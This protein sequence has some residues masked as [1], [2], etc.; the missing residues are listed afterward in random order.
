MEVWNSTDTVRINAP[1]FDHIDIAVSD[2]DASR[3]FYELALGPA[4]V[5][6]GWL[7]WGDF[8]ITPVD[9]E[10]PLTQRLHVALGVDSREAVDEWWRRLIEGGFTSDGEPGPRPEYSE[11]YY[12]GFVLD[13]DGN[14]VEAVHHG[15]SRPGAIDH[16]WLRTA[17]VVEAGLF[18]ETVAPVVGITIRH[19]EER[20]VTF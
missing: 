13:P 7:E 10:H 6:D 20:R 17:D 4:S 3:R 2:V 15:R 5:E 16:L 1:V 9:E 12:G 18:Y 19:R 8:G 14:S 11:E